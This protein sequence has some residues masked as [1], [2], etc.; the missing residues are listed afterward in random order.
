MTGA[1]VL[2][3]RACE[4]GEGPAYDPATGTLRWFN[5][6]AMQMLEMRWPDG[7]TVVH[8][9]PFMASALAAVDAKRQLLVTE[10]GFYLRDVATGELTLHTPLEA[11]NPATR[12]NDARVHPCGAFWAGTMGKNAEKGAGAIYRFF[13]GEVRQL[14]ANITIP[15]AICFS[16]D[17]TAA[18]FTDSAVNTMMRVACDPATGLPAGQPS[19]LHDQTGGKGALDGSVCDT[20]ANIWNARWGAGAVDV[21]KPDGT[22][23]ATHPVAATQTSCPVFCGPKADTVAVTTAWQGMDQKRRAADPGAGKLFRLAAKA[24]GRFDPPVSI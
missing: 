4:L 6:V 14:Y 22:R 1:T 24:N 18:Y 7:E 5:I 21:Y 9:L 2:S 20:D 15:N 11:D 16:P 17:G 8:D 19:V 3:D 10:R 23:I 13:R 12:S